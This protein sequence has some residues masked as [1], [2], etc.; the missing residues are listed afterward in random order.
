MRCYP[1][2]SVGRVWWIALTLTMLSMGQ[3]GAQTEE[4]PLDGFVVRQTVRVEAS[5]DLTYDAVVHRIAAWW[6]PEH[7]FSGEAAGLSIDPTPGGC[8]CEVLPGG[9]GVRHMTVVLVEPNRR[10][11]LVG[12]LGPLQ[13]SAVTGVM[14]W[15]FSARADGTD[16][17]LTY[18]VGGFR[19]GGL[20]EL[21]GAVDAVL[22]HQLG[23]L[24]DH[25]QQCGSGPGMGC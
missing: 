24:K 4:D 16:V 25:V 12:G 22:V 6:N 8:W 18:V 11:R 14:T 23:R 20:Q 1:E 7:T 2:R 17:V 10:L 3:V 9:G 15:E 13:E 21:A 19:P 5:P